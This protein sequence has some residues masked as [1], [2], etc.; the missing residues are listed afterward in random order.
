VQHIVVV[1]QHPNNTR[2]C[3]ACNSRK[4]LAGAYCKWYRSRRV[5]CG[6]FDTFVTGRF[7]VHFVYNSNYSLFTCW[8]LVV[9]WKCEYLFVSAMNPM[10]MQ[11]LVTLAAMTGGNGAN[12]QVSP[13]G[14]FIIV[15]CDWDG[16]ICKCTR[17]SQT[18]NFYKKPVQ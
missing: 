6:M 7:N 8:Y 11:N 15:V 13:T 1:I 3:T 18:L 12:L 14:E 17:F 5:E 9:S 10:S 2:L 16:N 4:A